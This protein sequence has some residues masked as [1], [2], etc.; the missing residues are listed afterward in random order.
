[1]ALLV[2]VYLIC[3]AA[4]AVEHEVRGSL[5][6]EDVATLPP[7]L[8][9]RL[10][11]YLSALDLSVPGLSTL[12]PARGL[13]EPR[14]TA[15]GRGLFAVSDQDSEFQQLRYIPLEGAPP[16]DREAR[17]LSAKIP[18]DVEA[19]TLS[20]DGRYLLYVTNED[21]YSRLN[22]RD[23]RNGLDLPAPILPLGRVRDLS[24]SPDNLSVAVGLETARAAREEWTYDIGAARLHPPA[25]EAMGAD[26]G[27]FVDPRLMRFPTIDMTAGSPRQIPAFVYRPP[28]SGPFPVLIWLEGGTDGQ[29]RPGFNPFIQFLVAELRMTVIAPNVRGSNGYG[30]SYRQ[31]DDGLRREDAI[32]DIG[33]LIAWIGQQ[34]DLDRTCVLVMGSGYGGYLALTAVMHFGDRLLG[35]IDHAGVGNLISLL[36]RAREGRLELL[37]AEYGNETDPQVRAYLRR[38]SPLQNSQRITRPLLVGQGL[39]DTVAPATET[40]QMIAAIRGRGGSVGYLLARDEGREFRGMGNRRAWLQAAAAFIHQQL[41]AADAAL[42]AP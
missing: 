13:T 24:F 31:L 19:F 37:R 8:A 18:W 39:N 2:I 30:R 17:R 14:T 16:A 6:L 36:E 22:L 33:A 11:P 26:S 7:D 34:G 10:A 21:G 38:I 41:A 28:G 12:A 42:S 20:D 9:A 25:N 3:A 29:F 5:V 1:M 40:E 23:A 4:G 15:D 35:G 32:K 27:Q